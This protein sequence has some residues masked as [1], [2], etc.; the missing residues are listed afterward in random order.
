VGIKYGTFHSWI[1]GEREPRFDVLLKI[2]KEYLEKMGKNINI[3]FL[4]SGEGEMFIT[5]D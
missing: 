3:D 5:K 4:I 2:K 1:R